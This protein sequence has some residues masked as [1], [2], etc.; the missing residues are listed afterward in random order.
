MIYFIERFNESDP[1][2]FGAEES[3]TVGR[4]IFD[5]VES[6]TDSKLDEISEHVLDE[7]QTFRKTNPRETKDI[8]EV[9]KNQLGMEVKE[10]LLG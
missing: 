7:N 9:I 5:I 2:F 1:M 6:S 4:K 8:T 10:I 3:C